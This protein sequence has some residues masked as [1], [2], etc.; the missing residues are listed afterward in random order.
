[1]KIKYII[2]CLSFYIFLM[3]N[4]GLSKNV[5]TQSYD[6]SD[7]LLKDSCH[8]ITILFEG[9]FNGIGYNELEV[10]N[11]D[12]STSLKVFRGKMFGT[13]QIEYKINEQLLDNDS[14]LNEIKLYRRHRLVGRLQIM[15]DIPKRLNAEQ[16]YLLI[17]KV[18]SF[19]SRT[20]YQFQ[21]MT[22]EDYILTKKNN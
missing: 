7:N 3:I 8:Q 18:S 5:N 6:E 12:S 9:K 22:Y 4:D 16:K 19:R 2:L 11:Q 14:L 13:T 21:W 1:M 20:P 17:K 10:L 15:Q